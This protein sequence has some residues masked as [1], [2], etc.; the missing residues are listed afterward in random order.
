MQALC[1][2]SLVWEGKHQKQQREA[3]QVIGETRDH[4]AKDSH[5]ISANPSE[6]RELGCPVLQKFD[7]AVNGSVV[8]VVSPCPIVAALA[9]SRAYSPVRSSPKY[10]AS[11]TL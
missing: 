9:M 10:S 4:V 5:K 8:L 11:I 1:A 6:V 3:S 2:M 7:F